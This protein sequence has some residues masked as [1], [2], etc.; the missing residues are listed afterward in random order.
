MARRRS[1]NYP[2][3][4]LQVAIERIGVIH[5][6]QGQAPEPREVVAKHLGFGGLNGAALKVLSALLK[7]GLLDDVGAGE[8]R[9]SDTAINILAPNSEQEKRKAIELAAFSYPLF[10][11]FRERWEGSMPSEESLRAYLVRRHFSETAIK[12]VLE[13]YKDTLGLIAAPPKTDSGP[14]F[15][16]VPEEKVSAPASTMPPTTRTQPSPSSHEPFEV[17]ITDRIKGWFSFENQEDLDDLISVLNAIRKRLPKSV[18]L[19]DREDG[20]E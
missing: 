8:C 6:L 17:T 13:S 4:S 2:G 15:E 19:E 18:S 10:A 9:V 11:E 16:G 5:R 3:I 12:S 1:P 14:P 20:L 7:Y